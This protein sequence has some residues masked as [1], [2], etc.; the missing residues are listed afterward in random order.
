MTFDLHYLILSPLRTSCS[1]PNSCLEDL[2]E[3]SSQLGRVSCD[4]LLAWLDRKMNQSKSNNNT[5]AGTSAWA[6]L[7]AAMSRS[8][9]SSLLGTTGS[10]YFISKLWAQRVVVQEVEKYACMNVRWNIRIWLK[11]VCICTLGRWQPRQL[12][13]T[14]M[15]IR[16]ACHPVSSWMLLSVCSSHPM[17][18]LRG[19]DKS[20]GL[21]L[22]GDLKYA[23]YSYY[24]LLCRYFSLQE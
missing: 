22:F 16:G 1:P 8:G 18:F 4:A 21:N 3:H 13:K 17:F 2:S 14:P 11:N 19:G 24:I 12:M 20:T 23:H 5:S 7:C 10:K 6:T 15:I 9:L